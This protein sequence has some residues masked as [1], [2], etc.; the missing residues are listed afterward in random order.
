MP[1][2][3][4]ELFQVSQTPGI[5]PNIQV[6]VE[7]ARR[8]LRKKSIADLW[9]FLEEVFLPTLG[10]GKVLHQP[11]HGPL[12]EA[13][14][15]HEDLLVLMARYTLKT[16][17][18]TL[19]YPVWLA[20]NYPDIS[21]MLA[22][23]SMDNPRDWMQAINSFMRL[24]QVRWLYPEFYSKKQLT[25]EWTH[26]GRTRIHPNPTLFITGTDKDVVGKHPHV[27]I[28][29]DLI[30]ETQRTKEALERSERWWVQ[31]QPLIKDQYVVSNDNNPLFSIVLGTPWS[32]DTI[33]EK[34]K[35]NRPT[36]RRGCYEVGE[37]KNPKRDAE[38]KFVI[39]CPTLLSHEGLA[40]KQKDM[41]AAAFSAQFL[42][43][44]IS[45]ES[46][47]FKIADIEAGFYDE[48]KL[49]A[50]IKE[51]SLSICLTMDVAESLDQGDRSAIVAT[52]VDD[53]GDVWVLDYIE[54]RM[55]PSESFAHLYAMTEKWKAWC[56]Y[57]EP[58]GVG[59]PFLRALNEEMRRRGHSL[60]VREV[61]T[62]GDKETRIT[63]LLEPILRRRALHMRKDMVDLISQ[64][65][66]FPKVSH[67]DCLDAL[68]MRCERTVW[69]ETKIVHRPRVPS[70]ITHD[71]DEEEDD[72]LQGQVYQDEKNRE[73]VNRLISRIDDE[74]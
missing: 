15:K 63:N 61:K 55:L 1:S 13:L 4:T 71:I 43:E 39:A 18:C 22:S 2:I 49:K 37:D 7:L 5:P 59:G 50:L 46:K 60:N 25:E 58:W 57:V 69:A 70:K 8:K 24:E 9:L 62:R 67:E 36:I 74:I 30:G 26:P 38:G 72:S 66:R 16:T 48:D 45:E 34:I 53:Q 20:L 47:P 11:Y 21:I 51:K 19:A 6:D 40:K 23:H 68:A 41:T 56:V 65:S 35:E 32:Y 42:M 28:V 3:L 52:G 44:P 27:I 33:Y 14:Q 10:E 12:V 64:M 54:D 31:A 29:D 73:K 17:I